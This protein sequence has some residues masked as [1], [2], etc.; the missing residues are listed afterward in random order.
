[1]RKEIKNK[2]HNIAS[3]VNDSPKIFQKYIEN[4]VTRKPGIP[5]LCISVKNSIMTKTGKEN[6]GNLTEHFSEVFMDELAGDMSIL[7]TKCAPALTDIVL[8]GRNEKC[9]KKI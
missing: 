5:N 9:Y 1:M 4:K 8:N 3:H 2:E 6:A 7:P